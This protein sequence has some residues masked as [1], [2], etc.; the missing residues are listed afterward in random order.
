[1]AAADSVLLFPHIDPDPDAI[2][3]CLALCRALRQQ[4]KKAWILTDPLAEY[5]QFTVRHE[6]DDN[7]SAE[8]PG[9]DP[10]GKMTTQNAAVI[11]QPDICV[12]VD[13]SEDKRISGR[14]E[15]FFS[16]G[17]TL[18]IDHHRVSEC[19]YDHYHIDPALAAT[20]QLVYRMMQEMDWPLD[21]RIA[22]ALYA[23]IC[24][25]TGCFMHSN[26]T[27]EIHRIAADLQEHGVDINYVNVNLY[28]SKD[29]RSVRVSV[30]ALEAMELLADGRAVISKLSNEDFDACGAKVEHADTVIDDLRVIRGVEIAA[31]L[32]ENGD[33]VRGNLRSKTDANVAEIAVKFGGGGHIKAAGFTAYQPLDE[34]YEQLKEEI[35]RTLG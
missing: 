15:A 17:K 8:D 26:T 12:M 29:L 31:F 2:G 10:N 16:G 19:S 32:K 6:A 24:G 28:Q 34:V 5:L 9:R 27:P 35:L 23:G 20:A 11:G 3:S 4:G 13:C 1:M 18:C 25:D 14:E 7:G 22:E 33:K 30:K 21:E